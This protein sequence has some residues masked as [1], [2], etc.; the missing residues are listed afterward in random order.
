MSM[1]TSGEGARPERTAFFGG[2]FDPPH[3]GHLAIARAAADRLGLERI[4]VAP[5][6]SQ[7]LKAG[8]PASRF[9]DRLAMVELAFADDPRCHP[10]TLDAPRAD[11]SHNYT[12]D[13]LAALKAELARE[14]VPSNLFCLLGA[15]SFH[16]LNHWH[17][18]TDLVL[19]CDFVV[20]ARPGYTLEAVADCLP[21]GVEIRGREQAPDLL[22]LRL[23]SSADPTRTSTLYVLPDL[24]ED[25]SATALRQALAVGDTAVSDRMLTPS[26]AAY[27]RGHGLYRQPSTP[28][29]A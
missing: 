29:T 19:L 14:A 4:L 17:R 27:I 15:D 18:A 5:V 9:A 23:E 21:P 1:A 3:L 25:V 12:Y 24:A 28:R 8:F 13:T 11:G 16:T 6:G 20:A 26:V 2:T 22:Q 10:S 7:P